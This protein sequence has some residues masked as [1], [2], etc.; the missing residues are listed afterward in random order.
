MLQDQKTGHLLQHCIKMENS[1]VV[2]QSSAKSEFEKSR[3]QSFLYFKLHIGGSWLLLTVS[4]DS[5]CPTAIF[6]L[7]SKT[8]KFSS[9]NLLLHF[10]QPHYSHFY[11]ILS[12]LP[13]RVNMN[14]KL[15]VLG[16][17]ES[18]FSNDGSI[19]ILSKAKQPDI[20]VQKLRIFLR[21]DDKWIAFLILFF[22]FQ[23]WG[24]TI[25]YA[26]LVLWKLGIIKE[27]KVFTF[28]I[29]NI[30]KVQY[31]LPYKPWLTRVRFFPNLFN[32]KLR[33]RL[34]LARLVDNR[35]HRYNPTE[36]L[37]KFISMNWI[38]RPGIFSILSFYPLL[39]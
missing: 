14:K 11:E 17:K 39:N 3:I 34:L 8:S 32:L 35:S 9:S 12:S 4:M 33:F 20:M 27:P 24:I 38:I 29:L 28:S 2:Q 5:M 37:W 18:F 13:L 23:S 15:F 31:K 30:F 22:Y 21:W 25:K 7:S 16:S 1:L 6:R 19:S 26:R 36:Q 10:C